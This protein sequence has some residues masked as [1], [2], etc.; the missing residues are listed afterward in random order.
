MWRLWLGLLLLGADAYVTFELWSREVAQGTW[1][2]MLL[3]TAI[4]FALTVQGML[5]WERRSG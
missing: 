4:G 2:F 3:W 1:K 5:V